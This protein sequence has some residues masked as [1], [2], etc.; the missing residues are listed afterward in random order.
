MGTTV[1]KSALVERIKAGDQEA[2]NELI[3]TR[4]EN[5]CRTIRTLLRGFNPKVRTRTVGGQPSSTQVN[6]VFNATLIRLID[7]IQSGGPTPEDN[8]TLEDSN[9]AGYMVV[10]ARN[11]LLYRK[12]KEIRDRSVGDEP[13]TE[14]SVPGSPVSTIAAERELAAKYRTILAGM[15][16][17]CRLLIE[18]RMDAG[19]SFDEIGEVLKMGPKTARARYSECI[20][21]LR[22]LGGVSNTQG[23]CC[24]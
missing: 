12:R 4:K 8:E 19:L 22:Q 5:V 18:L 2:M 16:E 10:I 20:V 15:P 6:S 1:N 11:L 14:V 9:L 24:G 21:K 13:L 17:R 7:R 23:E 3:V